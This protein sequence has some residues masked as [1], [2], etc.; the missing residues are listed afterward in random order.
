V[1]QRDGVRK[2][3]NHQGTGVTGSGKAAD[4]YP[5]RNGK[6]FIPGDSDPLWNTYATVVTRHG[7]SAGHNFP[8]F[9]D[10]PHCE[11]L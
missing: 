7:L 6:V 10:S 2:L 8:N 1:T 9:K 5:M 3:S 4:C 11:L